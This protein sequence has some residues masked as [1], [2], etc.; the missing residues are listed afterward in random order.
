TL[1]SVRA[2]WVLISSLTCAASALVAGLWV[3]LGP[4]REL[5]ETAELRAQRAL[6]LDSE[7]TRNA[8]KQVCEHDVRIERLLLEVMA[9]LENNSTFPN[10]DDLKREATVLA[11]TLESSLSGEV[12]IYLVLD[13]WD[14][15][16]ARQPR[17]DYAKAARQRRLATTTGMDAELI[18]ACSRRMR[19]FW[20]WIVRAKPLAQVLRDAG[21]DPEAYTSK[22]SEPQAKAAGARLV[23]SA[24]ELIT[25]TPLPRIQ[26]DAQHK[27]LAVCCLFAAVLGAILGLFLTRP[28]APV[29]ESVLA[30]LEQAAARVASGDL[31]SEIGV[32]FGGRADQTVR[33]FDRMTAE[34]R[35]MRAKLA[36]AERA[37]AWQ[38]MAQRIA[39]EIRNP[40]SPIRMALETLR[41][42]HDKRLPAFD[43]I[44]AESTHAMLEEVQRLERIVREFSEFARLPKAR[45]GAMTLGALVQETARLYAP[46]DVALELE[47][48]ADERMIH[49]DREQLTQVL[50]NLI[51]NAVHAA[52]RRPSPRLA[53]RVEQT[54]EA[55]TLAVE[56]SGEGV[57]PEARARI[58]EPYVTSKSEGTGLGLSIARR[59]VSDHAGTIGVEQS[60]ALGGARFVVRLPA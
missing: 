50:V 29:D 25:V 28:R 32:R 57:A 6:A 53:L 10:L 40:L 21:F 3:A 45:P 4:Q 2:W 16:T 15:L 8:L 35:E 27:L 37:A 58:F 59:I 20:L 22:R 44:F 12:T 56:D 47:L 49:A 52:R 13:Q 31:S 11:R 18:D 14:Q 19:V 23:T 1:R 43:E 60:A 24:G 5:S 46:D 34:L 17:G 51:A 26:D 39:H 36:D 42:A 7:R 54:D 9:P 38:D 48:P 41:K 30:T 33:S 55:T